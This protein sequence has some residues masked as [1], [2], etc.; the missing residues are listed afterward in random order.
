MRDVIPAATLVL[1]EIL[2]VALG[3]MLMYRLVSGNI[4]KR[5]V[6]AKAVRR[7]RPG[8]PWRAIAFALHF[9]WFEALKKRLATS[10][11]RRP[12]RSPYGIPAAIAL[13]S[14]FPILVP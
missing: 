2:T 12:E 11:H 9:F 5:T 8:D 1:A 10:D 6:L 7:E 14:L 3:G 4:I 13:L